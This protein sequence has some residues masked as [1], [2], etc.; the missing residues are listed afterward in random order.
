[1]LLLEGEP[2]HFSTP[3]NHFKEGLCFTRDTRVFVI[4]KSLITFQGPYNTRDL[5]EDEMMA[6]RRKVFKCTRQIPIER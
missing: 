1:M 3:K 6:T 4:R 5:V 2:V